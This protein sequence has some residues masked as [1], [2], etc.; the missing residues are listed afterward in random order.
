MSESIRI[1]TDVGKDS[2]KYLKISLDQDYDFIEILSLNITQEDAYRKFSSDYGVIV[3]RVI[4][5]SGFGVPNA[6]VSVFIPLDDID[7]TD[8]VISGLYPYEIITDKN[9]DGIR[10]NIL[11]KESETNND[12]FTPI[13]T[14][15]TKREV[16]DNDVMLGIYCKYYKFTTTTNHAGDFMIFGVPLG[17]Y[18]VHVDADISD[19]GEASQRPYDLIRQGAP[20]KIFESGTK[21]KSGSN[22]DKLPQVKSANMGVN[23]QPFWGDTESY[24]IGITRLDVDL[25]YN[26]VPAAIFVG[27]IFGDQDKHSINKHCSPRQLLGEV[28]EQVVGPGTIEMIRKTTDNTIE[29]FDVEG[30]R[31]IDND[32]TWA[33]QIP[34]NL[35]YVVTDETGN[36]ILSQDPN[37][38]IPTR[39]SV[40]FRVSMDETGGE[41]RLRTRAKYLVPN[42]PENTNEIDYDFGDN[43]KDTSFKDLYWN[44]IYTVSNFI[45]RYQNDDILTLGNPFGTSNMI[46]NPAGTRNMT[47]IKNVD[48]CAGDKTPFP[49]NRINTEVN[50]IFVII[51]LI[52]SIIGFLVYII[53]ILFVPLINTVL[54]AIYYVINHIIIDTANAIIDAIDYIITVPKM[55][56]VSEDYIPC[57]T[58]QC[59]SDSGSYFS[60]GCDGSSDGWTTAQKNGYQPTYYCGS[61]PDGCD[62]T[63]LKDCVAFEMAKALG[64]FQL[65][66]YNDWINGTLFSYLLKY[67][68]KT[69]GKEKF[70]EYDCSSFTSSQGYS[71]V[72]GNNDGDPDNPCYTHV[73]LD[74]LFDSSTGSD[75]QNNYR[76]LSVIDGLIKAYDGEL[77]YASTT[78]GMEGKLFATD[79]ICLGSVF[80]CDWQGFPF[81]QPYLIPTTYKIP[82]DIEERG[83]DCNKNNVTIETGFVTLDKTQG[84]LCG[85]DCIGIN[86]NITQALNIRHLCEFG[87]NIDELIEDQIS[88]TTLYSP[89]GVIGSYDIDDSIG[90]EFRDSF[91]ILNSGTTSANSFEYPS[92]INTNFNLSN[93]ALYYNFTEGTNNGGNNG[94]SYV[95]FRGTTSDNSYNQP[96]HS[97]YFYFGLLPGKTSLDKM[98]Q[99]YFTTCPPITRHDMIIES[100]V[101]GDTGNTSSGSISFVFVGGHPVYSYTITGPNNYSVN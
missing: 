88:C 84:L 72:D 28:C 4:I 92:G 96:N 64:I 14:F 75:K 87:V 46:V 71:G 56:K 10:Y 86:V 94:Q 54:K 17:T 8:S 99:R 82:P 35:D 29:S 23:V 22:L 49:F 73:L 3:G 5:N 89:D 101:S 36:L 15:P 45:T 97:Y 74:T 44:K 91:F 42:N 95:D 85:I 48:A 38:G 67:K 69:N 24:E 61:N 76:D 43:T 81:L 25:N 63:A 59:P 6:K 37:I 51:C 80:A 31:L 79:I 18:T 60:P 52:L 27:S 19:I 66:F 100:S 34:M 58:V 62:S 40:R 78:H 12:C 93:T 98:N 30:G 68:K 20:D 90:K 26:I 41:G 2:D 83:L 21:F 57:V 77:Y 16:L 11:P 7:K 47:G 9:S 32:G 65:D 13:G 70:C 33:Y 39:S 55:T 50:P 53:N 1:K